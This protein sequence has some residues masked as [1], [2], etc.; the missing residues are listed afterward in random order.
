MC[1][2]VILIVLDAVGAGSLPDAADYGDAGA[3]TLGHVAER[4]G[5]H[6]P[7]MEA[8]GLGNIERTGFQSVIAPKAVYGRL[9]ERSPGKDT[10]TGHW[11]LAGLILDN[12]F[13]I[14][15]PFP[16]QFIETWE[17]SIGRTCLGNYAAS[18]TEIIEHLGI[19]HMR[20]GSPIVYTSADSVF[21]IAAHEAI[22]PLSEL[23]AICEEARALLTGEWAVARVI[24]RPFDGTPG[25]FYRTAGRRDFSLL[26]TG[27]TLLDRIPVRGIGKIEDIFAHQ[28]LTASDHAAGNLACLEALHKDMAANQPGLTFVN[29]VD[30]DMLYGHR[31]D[32]EGFA[33]CLL[34]FDTELPKILNALGFEDLCIITADHGCD[35]THTG[36]DH[37]REYAPALLYSPSMKKGQCMGERETFADIAET[38]LAWLGQPTIGSGHVIMEVFS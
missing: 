8:L 37:T 5:I 18:G 13:P 15:D 27:E 9:R 1:R 11:E 28:G 22:I 6:L 35:P 26:P 2:R 12:P 30:T 19:E 34:E 29:L 17:A 7:H 38:V 14:F 10:T 23:Y 32:V 20:T 4:T 24:A 36:T 3:N 25:S 31:R 16:V 33:R 21:Q